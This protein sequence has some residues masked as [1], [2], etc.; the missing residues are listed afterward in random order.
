MLLLTGCSKYFT[1]DFDQVTDYD[2]AD[3][4]PFIITYSS[5]AGEDITQNMY[6]TII[7][8]AQNGELR[9]YTE[10]RDSLEIHDDAP[11]LKKQLSDD[12]VKDVQDVIEE[13]GFWKLPKDVTAPSEDGSF[14]YV[15][16]NLKDDSKKVGGLNPDN[17]RYTKIRHS[18]TSLVDDDEYAEWKEE[19][20]E[21][22]WEHNSLYINEKT[23]YSTDEP[24]LLLRT[25][26]YNE[27]TY[28]HNIS[29]DL[30]GNL[31]LNMEG[32][33]ENEDIGDDAPTI[34][35][36]LTK[37]ELEDIQDLIQEHFWKMNTNISN[38]DGDNREESITVNLTEE[39]KEVS[40]NSPVNERFTTIRDKMIDSVGEKDYE[41]WADKIDKYVGE[42]G[43]DD[44]NEW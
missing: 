30:D 12:E 19:I 38:P 9:V 11:V 33:Y 29:I 16:V 8:I 4:E 32:G 7:S 31:V 34:D 35:K 28:Y 36:E 24:F 15:T 10:G 43:S 3:D 26:H 23:D 41:K 20:G 6:R 27:Q 2:Y 5:S 13:Q 42:L 22:I 21:H 25:E 39:S 18:V 14:S 40:G 37:A 17:D 44:N 1:Y